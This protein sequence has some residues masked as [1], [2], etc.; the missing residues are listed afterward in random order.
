MPKIDVKSV[1]EVKGTGYPA[2]FDAPCLERLRKRLGD[3]GGLTQFGVNLLTLAPGT[4][5]SQRH[6]H[7]AEDEF[8]YV[9]SGEIVLITGAGEEILRA[10]DC[11][12]FPKGAADG[13]HLLN[14][15]DALAVC[16]EIGTR[17]AD[18]VC[19]Y[20]DLDLQIDSKIGWYAHKDGTPYPKK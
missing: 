19:L 20:P 9:L 10:G 17:S 4:W 14:K 1:P 7:S 16:L 13:H 6:W 8:V 5:S 2:P 3:A 11:A 12:A 18:D 15:S